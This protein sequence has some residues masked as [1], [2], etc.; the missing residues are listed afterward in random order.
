MLFNA[1]TRPVDEQSQKDEM[2]AAVRGDRERMLQRMRGEGREPVFVPDEPTEEQPPLPSP[3]E[4]VAEVAPPEPE[5]IPEPEPELAPLAVAE[6]EP[7]PE[8]EVEAEPEPEPEQPAR[9]GFLARLR[10]LFGGG[11]SPPE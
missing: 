11:A 7:E 3:P 6:P 10:R 2:R 9:P 4:P 8:P 5:P 1:E